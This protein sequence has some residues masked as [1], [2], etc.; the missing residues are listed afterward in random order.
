MCNSC[1]KR[2]KHVRNAHVGRT[3]NARYT[4]EISK[5]TARAP[6]ILLFIR[7]SVVRLSPINHNVQYQMSV[8]IILRQF[9]MQ[10]PAGMA[11][12]HIINDLTVC[13][14]RHI[15]VFF[16][17]YEIANN[18][19]CVVRQTQGLCRWNARFYS[20]FVESNRFVVDSP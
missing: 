13:F 8:H 12:V 7:A 16:V 19:R 18:C 9:C 2:K 14:F 17:F 20:I 11:F 5:I 10:L 4:H 15:Y 3:S 1:V 6:K